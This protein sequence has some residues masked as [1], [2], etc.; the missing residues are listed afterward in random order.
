[1]YVYIYMEC[2]CVYIYIYIHIR[3][4]TNTP[5]LYL[6]LRSDRPRCIRE[7]MCPLQSRRVRAG[8]FRKQDDGNLSLKKRHCMC[9]VHDMSKAISDNSLITGPC[10]SVCGN[11]RGI[12]SCA[13]AHQEAS[14]RY[15][16]AR[17]L[18]FHRSFFS[19][20]LPLLQWRCA[21]AILGI[22]P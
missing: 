21:H 12:A 2:I 8:M 7:C 18:I 9:R 15:A 1:M 19:Q 22:V 4:Y 20:A 10:A 11:E 17:I 13:R 5:V 16:C 3:T 14:D 6:A